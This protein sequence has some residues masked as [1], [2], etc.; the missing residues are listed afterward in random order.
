MELGN[1]KSLPGIR[2]EWG[3]GKNSF[4]DLQGMVLSS[5][6]NTG[7]WSYDQ[8]LTPGPGFSTVRRWRA[9]FFHF[10][11]SKHLSVWFTSFSTKTLFLVPFL[12][13]FLFNKSTIS[14]SF[15]VH[16][17]NHSLGINLSK[18]DL[19]VLIFFA[20]IFCI[21]MCTASGVLKTNINAIIRA[22]FSEP[23][24]KVWV[25]VEIFVFFLW[26]PL[27]AFEQKGKNQS[28][29]IRI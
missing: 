13:Q 22:F 26:I 10:S 20:Y 18:A 24:K 12:N 6:A 16:M 8:H 19:C 23:V 2:Q 25:E 9:D 27:D 14:T 3:Q 4:N 11:E 5:Y 21:H 15:G 29:F 7:V 28:V 17:D 1:A